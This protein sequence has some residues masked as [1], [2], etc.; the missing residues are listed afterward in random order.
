MWGLCFLQIP[1]LENGQQWYEHAGAR[2][3]DMDEFFRDLK[4][5]YASADVPSKAE[6]AARKA[7]KAAA[8]EAAT[9]AAAAPA[10]AA[11]VAGKPLAKP[12][13][14]AVPP[15]PGTPVSLASGPT[16]RKASGYSPDEGSAGSAGQPPHAANLKRAAPSSAGPAPGSAASPLE[17]AAKRLRPPDQPHPQSQPR[18]QRPVSVQAQPLAKA[19]PAPVPE[20]EREPGELPEDGELPLSDARPPSHDESAPAMPSSSN[21]SSSSWE[22]SRCTLPQLEMLPPGACHSP[23]LCSAILLWLD[24]S[25]PRRSFL[26]FLP[27]YS[28]VPCTSFWLSGYSP[29][30]AYNL[31]V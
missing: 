28:Q 13:L 31:V 20:E 30:A 1:P 23:I 3:Q 24:I 4:R 26:P 19:A 17:P 10:G 25:H 12:Q 27:P 9:K 21:I 29:S 8:K 16:Q 2:T 11:A 5:L 6:K 18:L 14:A 22:P 7:A 15:A